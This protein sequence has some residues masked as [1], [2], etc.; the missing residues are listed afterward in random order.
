MPRASHPHALW[1]HGHT[2]HVRGAHHLWQ[3]TLS[4]EPLQAVDRVKLFHKLNRTTATAF[5]G[6]R[7]LESAKQVDWVPI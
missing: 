7:H 2:A 3:H 1:R 6:G 5:G 4:S